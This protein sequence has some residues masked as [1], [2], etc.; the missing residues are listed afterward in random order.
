MFL[1]E[2]DIVE[3]VERQAALVE[4]AA[5]GV[6]RVTGVPLF[7]GEALLLRGGGIITLFAMTDDVPKCSGRCLVA[8]PSRAH[9]RYRGWDD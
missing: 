8:L 3:V 2:S 1:V 9:G 5:N 6:L 7:A 4:T